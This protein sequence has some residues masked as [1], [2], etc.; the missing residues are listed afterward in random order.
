MSARVPFLDLHRVTADCRGELDAAVERVLDSGRFV[1]GDAVRSF[2]SA[3]ADV[4]GAA[5][6]I[7]VGSG[8]DAVEIALRAVGVRSGDEVVT[9]ANTCPPTAAAIARIGAVPVLCDV[10]L[11]SAR[12]DPESLAAAIGPATRAL[13]PVHL[14]GQCADMPAIMDVAE[15]HGVPVVE[16]C[17]QAHLATFDGRTAGTMGAAG[18]FSFYPT[19]NLGALG[20]GGMVVSREPGLAQA[21][22]D[23]RQYAAFGTAGG[24][25]FGTN[26]RLD[27][28]QAAVLEAK[29]PRLREWTQ[30]RAAI[31]DRYCAA[32]AQSPIRPLEHDPRAGHVHHLFVVR[33]PEREHVRDLLREYGVDT[34][35]HY[36]TPIH[37]LPAYAGEVRT[38]VPLD[39][40]ERLAGEVLSLPLYPQLSDDEVD[41]V[42]TALVK[43]AALAA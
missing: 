22:E 26:S 27:E 41:R 6:A 20:D 8:T 25:G 43:C 7:G 16:D 21:L 24:R 13:V 12:M 23:L 42:A 2:E 11:E 34:L 15:R 17:A 32:L 1:L 35:V 10:D 40:S 30:R 19:K 5:T 36:P 14:Y 28:I 31:A 18:C 33:A 37:L 9:Q 39:R 29:L 38:P 3:F 4:L